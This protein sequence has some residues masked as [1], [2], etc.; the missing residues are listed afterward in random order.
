MFAVPSRIARFS[1][2][3]STRGPSRGSFEL[4]GLEEFG[5]GSVGT[6]RNSCGG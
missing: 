2:F 4:I 5:G 3:G 6:G 1:L